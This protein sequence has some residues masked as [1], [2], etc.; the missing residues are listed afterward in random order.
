MLSFLG[1]ASF[2]RK[3]GTNFSHDALDGVVAE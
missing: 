3:T 2:A 1:S